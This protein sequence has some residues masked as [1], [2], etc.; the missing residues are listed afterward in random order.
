MKMILATGTLLLVGC[1]GLNTVAAE[2][3]DQGQQL[4]QVNSTAGKQLPGRHGKVINDAALYASQVDKDANN[5]LEPV[6]QKMPVD[7]KIASNSVEQASDDDC[8]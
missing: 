6:A 5:Q 1:F 4:L 7:E 8:D 2:S 3:L